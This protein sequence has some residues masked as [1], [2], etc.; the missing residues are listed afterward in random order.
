[1]SLLGRKSYAFFHES[2]CPW[3]SLSLAL[4]DL[5]FPMALL[6]QGCWAA[7]GENMRKEER[8]WQRKNMCSPSNGEVACRLWVMLRPQSTQR[9]RAAW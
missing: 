9:G 1:M 4:P 2:K 5:G 8:V 3:W 7:G 6:V